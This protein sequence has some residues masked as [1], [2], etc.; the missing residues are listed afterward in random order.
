MALINPYLEFFSALPPW[1]HRDPRTPLDARELL[2]P[3]WL[4]LKS[5]I[6]GHFAWAVPTPEATAAIARHARR[7]IEIGCGSGYWAWQ[8]R[9][10]GID[11]LAFDAAPPRF[12]WTEVRR[13][14]EL[15]AAAHADRTLFLCWPPWA[16]PM[17]A[18]AVALSRA[19]HVV[20]VGEWGGGCA[21]AR[22]FALLATLFEPVAAVALPQWYMRTD[23]LTVFRRCRW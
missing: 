8:M 2:Q 15:E 1:F 14:T 12:T 4:A 16:S 3:D 13:G 18:N 10:V 23:A 22:F 6:A 11:V 19:E 7:V 5:A 17:A 9:Q 21:D 20:Y